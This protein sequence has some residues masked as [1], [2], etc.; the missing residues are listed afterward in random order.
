MSG[1]SV[2]IA[3]TKTERLGS[4]LNTV[5]LVKIDYNFA[6]SQ[7]DLKHGENQSCSGYWGTVKRLSQRQS[8]KKHPFGIVTISIP[9]GVMTL[10]PGSCRAL[11]LVESDAS[12][13]VGD[14][15]LHN[16]LDLDPRIPRRASAGHKSAWPIC[17]RRR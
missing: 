14:C 10:R 11:P 12:A 4:G 13:E 8:L 9:C 16:G 5:R 15:A 17:A 7:P 6:I 1:F 3:C 2:V